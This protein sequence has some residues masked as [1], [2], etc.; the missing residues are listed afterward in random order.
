L[1]ADF[2]GIRDWFVGYTHTFDLSVPMIQVKY[3]H[4]FDVMRVG[5]T[6]IEALSWPPANAAVGVAACLLHDTGRFSQYRDFGTYYDG[7]SVDHGDRGYEILRAEFPRALVDDEAWEVLLQAV[8]QHNKKNLPEVDPQAA[9]FCRL[10]RDSDKLDVFKM[11]DRR[12]Q[13]GTVAELLPRHR[14]DAPLS[15]ALLDEIER[16]RSGSYKNAASLQDFLLI[17]LTWMLDLNFAPSFQMLEDS[18]VP[19]RIRSRFPQNDAGVQGLLDRLFAWIAE[20][21]QAVAQRAV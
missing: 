3:R 16:N 8:K 18:G 7:A 11:V 5:R 9:P 4:S 19:A 15:K 17:Q 2:D 10:T 21:R 20:H 13:E 12:I 6:L 14:I 1:F